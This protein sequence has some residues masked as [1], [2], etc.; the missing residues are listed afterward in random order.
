MAGHSTRE[1]A[2]SIEAS[3]R[4]RLQLNAVHFGSSVIPPQLDLASCP[5]VAAQLGHSVGNASPPAALAW[6]RMDGSIQVTLPA[7]QVIASKK[8]AVAQG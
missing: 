3:T 5:P 4:L 8:A 1:A 6:M 2:Q 7:S